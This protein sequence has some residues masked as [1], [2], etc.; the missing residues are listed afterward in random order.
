MI[1]QARRLS[2]LRSHQG[3]LDHRG[4]QQARTVEDQAAGQSV[5]CARHRGVLR[6]EQPVV[7][8]NWC[9]EPHGMVNRRELKASSMIDMRS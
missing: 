2:S 4:N 3:L 6:E 9:V 7:G 1:R 8:V 5:T